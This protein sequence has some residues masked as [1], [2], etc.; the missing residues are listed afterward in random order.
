MLALT[1][2]AAT[3]WRPFEGKLPAGAVAVEGL[4]VCRYGVEGAEEF[5]AGQLR[6]GRCESPGFD[7]PILEREGFDVLVVTSAKT[8]KKATDP[9]APFLG[10]YRMKSKRVSAEIV[11]SKCGGTLCA[12]GSTSVSQWSALCKL[13][14]KVA[15]CDMH[16]RRNRDGAQYTGT[17]TL[18]FSG[19]GL[20]Y[21]YDVTYDGKKHYKDTLKLNRVK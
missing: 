10:R 11:V 4:H 1:S 5:I 14:G 8:A 2:G 17:N 16:G 18:S 12:N 15:H 7:A 6:D 13:K 21:R 20:T 9:R 3:R 19:N